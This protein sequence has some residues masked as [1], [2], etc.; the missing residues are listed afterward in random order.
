MPATTID[1]YSCGERYLAVVRDSRSLS[2][3][4]R[5]REMRMRPQIRPFSGIPD[6]PHNR[7]RPGHST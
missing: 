1:V 7:V 4:S 5:E 2:A 6:G 3:D